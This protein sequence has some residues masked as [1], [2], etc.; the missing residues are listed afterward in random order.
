MA[1]KKFQFP[2]KG[3][4]IV[5]A[6]VGEA[7]YFLKKLQEVQGNYDEFSYILSAFTS[8]AR[9][10]TFSLQAVMSKYP[11]FDTWYI[12]HQENLKK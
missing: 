12:P 5:A 6:K 2:S 8:A 1:V 4:Y 7:D 9:S 3:F 11:N 10:I